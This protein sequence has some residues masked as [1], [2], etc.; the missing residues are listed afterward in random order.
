MMKKLAVLIAALI[1]STGLVLAQEAPAVEAPAE[2]MAA[3][4]S[5]EVNNAICP[6]TG[7]TL[8]LENST[9][10]T[11]L[12]VQGYSFNVCPTGK[13]A[14]DAN[15]SAYTEQVDEAVADASAAAMD[16][17]EPA[18]DASASATEEAAAPAVEPVA[19]AVTPPSAY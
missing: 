10:Y 17:S 18:M 11:K 8:N 5:I 2:E 3:A 19:E 12:D 4:K 6:L 1:L 15:P 7:R 13:A 9:D 16:A 14:Y